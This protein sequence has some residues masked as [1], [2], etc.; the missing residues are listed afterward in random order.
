MKLLVVESPNKIKKLQKCL[1][2]DWHVIATVGHFRDLPEDELGVDKAT[3]SPK[4]VVGGAKAAVPGKLREA[5]AR[6]S[7][8]FLGTDADREGEAIA[9]HVAQVLQL[10][11][12]KRVRFK[13]L[14]PAA[15]KKAVAEAELVD[16]RLVDAQ[17]ARRVVDRLVGFEASPLLQP[18]G[19]RHSAGRVQSATLHLVVQRE[20]EREAFVAVP[21]FTLQ[22]RYREGFAAAGA[23]Q[24]KDGK[25]APEFVTIRRSG[26]GWPARTRGCRPP[27]FTENS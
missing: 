3:F 12:A 26:K 21:F 16:Q 5:A 25:W 15:L 23:L 11:K 24:S 22:A 19:S 10:A 27:R 7:E 13:E 6:S 8:V 1:G 17:Q 14:T 9:W 2:S 20:L 4:Y 18:Y